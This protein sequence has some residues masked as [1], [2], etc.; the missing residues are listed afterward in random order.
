MQT[1]ATQTSYDRVAQE[2][3]RRMLHELDHKPLDRE[4]LDRFA[5]QVIDKGRVADLGC[6]HRE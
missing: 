3:A 6:A 1:N 5:K 2:Y 4:L